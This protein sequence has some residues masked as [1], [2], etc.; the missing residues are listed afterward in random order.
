MALVFLNGGAMAG[1][2]LHGLLRGAPLVGATRTA[3][4][5]RFWSVG[6]RFP[7]LQPV[8]EG[9]VS[10]AGEVYDVPLP[11]L[12]D[13][14]LPAEP[15]ELELGVIEL[16]DGRP[17]LAMVLRRPATEPADLRDIS[18]RPDWRGYRSGG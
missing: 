16:A 13:S 6:D 8:D 18:D 2:P 15:P 4:R 3:P 7:A 17:C 10:V 5:Y 12:R 14:L 11:V 9:G 1:G